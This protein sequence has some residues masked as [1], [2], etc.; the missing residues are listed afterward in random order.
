MREG[1]DL[2]RRKKKAEAIRAAD[3]AKSAP[4]LPGKFGLRAVS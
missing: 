4:P 1:M 2:S 3:D